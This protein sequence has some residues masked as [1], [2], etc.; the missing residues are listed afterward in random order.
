MLNRRSLDIF[1]SEKMISDSWL[2]FTNGHREDDSIRS[3]QTK[4]LD[5]EIVC[6]RDLCC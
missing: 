2:V 1:T 5:K 4:R 6:V 3:M